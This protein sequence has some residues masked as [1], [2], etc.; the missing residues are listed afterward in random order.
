[1]GF[2]ESDVVVY[3][4]SCDDELY[5][6]EDYHDGREEARK[7]LDE[8]EYHGHNVLIGNYL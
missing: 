6:G 5:R 2:D 1:M 3:C 4:L 7:H 8:H